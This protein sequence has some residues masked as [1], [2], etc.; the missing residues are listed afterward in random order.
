MPV[1]GSPEQGRQRLPALPRP[2]EVEVP[3]GQDV[4]ELRRPEVKAVGVD[5][6]LNNGIHQDG[7][8]QVLVHIF[9][10]LGGAD[11]FTPGG[12][13]DK[14][15]LP[16]ENLSQLLPG[17]LVRG[18]AEDHVVVV[19]GGAGGLGLVGGGAKDHVAACGEV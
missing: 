7:D 15:P 13:G 16:T 11:G 6:G 17:G 19:P 2:F 4:F 3:G 12:Q 8:V 14:L 1:H 10:D 18:P 5:V 9:P